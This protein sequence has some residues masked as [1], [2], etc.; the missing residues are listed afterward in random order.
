MTEK[1][2]ERVR[3]NEVINELELKFLEKI[4]DRKLICYGA[5][6]IWPDIIRIIA[7]D[8]LVEF[9]VDRDINR[10]GQEYFGKEIKSPSELRKFDKNKYAV[11]VLAGA[12]EEIVKMLERRGWKNGVNIFNVYQYI[13]VY[14]EASFGPINK[15]LRFLDTVP[16]GIMN[17][18]PRKDS[19]KIGII[20]NAEG[21]NFG[22]TYIPYLV[23]LFLLL[24]WK[25][26]NAKLIVD[27]LH[28]EGDIELYEGHCAVCDYVRD[29]VLHKL[30]ILV[31]KEDILYIDPLHAGGGYLELPPEDVQECER[32]AEYSADWSKWYNCWNS[33]FKPK[34]VIQEEFA[35]IFK[36]NLSCINSFFDKNHFD[37]INAISALHKMAG[38]YYYAGKKRGM[39]VSSQDG[40]GGFTLICANGAASYG[41]DIPLFFE[42]MWGN[43][44]DKKE[45][46]DRA[47]QMWEKRKNASSKVSDMT[48]DAYLQKMKEKGYE[49]ISFQASRKEIEQVYDVVVP[50][51]IMNDGAALGM[52]TI[53]DDSKQWLEKTLEYVIYEL[54]ASVLIREHPAWQFQPD[55][56]AHLEM[57]TAYP[58]IFEP[59]EGNKSLRYV[60]SQEEINLYQYIE[61]CKVVIPW[62]STVGVEAGLMGKNVLVHTNVY[63][64]NAAFATHVRT[65]KDYFEKIR[66][67]V[68][69][70]KF[71]AADKERAY[72]DALKYFYY[73]MNRQLTTEFTIV[74]SFGTRDWMFDSFEE[75]L[76]AEGVDEV[77][78]IVGDNVPSVYLIE[79]QRRRKDEYNL[80][81]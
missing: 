39:R 76:T 30:E 5:S 74:N 33:R 70:G 49:N 4:R 73:T 32:I 21:L 58:E 61:Q 27:R 67:C 24:K 55:Y 64:Q 16:N 80:G 13:H 57:Y 42:K 45:I 72:E 10:W 38:V 1:Q 53:F 26:F 43:I 40:E 12:F 23:S 71:L 47:T 7:I 25:G 28:W 68:L 37:T 17:V 51:N 46:L 52:A 9:F 15:Y 50:L 75:L 60:K 31:P 29:V 54:K 6:S 48:I 59:Y 56:M 34:S 2:K 63:Y 14:K 79:K 41:E 3:I 77:I 81:K 19:E 62:T 22:T 66:Q 69:E 20:L 44:P 18:T 65:Q 11:V 78:Q 35:E 36:R 8:D